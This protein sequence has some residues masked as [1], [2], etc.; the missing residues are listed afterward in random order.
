MEFFIF[1]S[2]TICELKKRSKNNSV[3]TIA[4]KFLII[5]NIHTLLINSHFLWNIANFHVE[6]ENYCHIIF[7]HL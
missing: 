2:E 5:Q 6:K 4:K 7:C 1:N 3:L